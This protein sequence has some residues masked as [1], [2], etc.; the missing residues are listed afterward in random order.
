MTTEMSP[1]SMEF[2]NLW[3]QIEFNYNTHSMEDKC[4]EV[5]FHLA[6]YK[7]DFSI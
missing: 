7:S 6:V 5:K 1:T 4:A 2:G 3:G